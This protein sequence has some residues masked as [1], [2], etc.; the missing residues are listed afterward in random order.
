MKVRVTI[1]IE[2]AIDKVT[3][4][5]DKE[6]L[7]LIPMQYDH[8]IAYIIETRVTEDFSGIKEIVTTDK[9]YW[10]VIERIMK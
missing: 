2:G 3:T 9:E 7:N 6:V 5:S 1:K 10:E 8:V 4:S